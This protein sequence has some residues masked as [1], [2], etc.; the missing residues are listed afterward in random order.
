MSISSSGVPE[1]KLVARKRT[2]EDYHDGLD[3]PRTGRKMDNETGNGNEGWVPASP[4]PFVNTRYQL[5]GGMDTPSLAQQRAVEEDNVYSDVGYRKSLS[6][7]ERPVLRETRRGLWDE[8]EGSSYFPMQED[9]G[10]E[11]N[12][13]GGYIDG[14]YNASPRGDGW[15]RTALQV[16][17]GVAAKVWNFAR[18][19]EPSFEGSKL[20][21][22]QATRSIHLIILSHIS[23]PYPEEIAASGKKKEL[24]MVGMTENQRHCPDN[25]LKMT[26]YQTG[27]TIP[28]PNNR[29]LDLLARDAR[30]AITIPTTK[31]QR[32]GLL[33]RHCNAQHTYKIS[34]KSSTS[35]IQH[36][37][38]LLGF[39]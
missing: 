1:R 11:E 31:L 24:S 39:T 30:L 7:E 35:Q 10:I 37:H 5:A 6:G 12:N 36:T 15:S 22:E 21:A 28:N 34:A 32:I 8:R 20:V 17:G 33:F 29:L 26:S 16:V 2:L 27:W 25:F 14:E 13:E 9:V 19:A 3:T 18:V 4:K 38:R 23:R